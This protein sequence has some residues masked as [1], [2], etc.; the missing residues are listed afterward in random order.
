MEINKFT[1]KMIN[2]R[3]PSEIKSL[4]IEEQIDSHDRSFAQ[5]KSNFKYNGTRIYIK[6][7][8]D[9][10]N[11]TI[12]YITQS[13]INASLK[14]DMIRKV[15]NRT[16]KTKYIESMV[17]VKNKDRFN[18]KDEDEYIDYIFEV[19]QEIDMKWV[20]L[21][22]EGKSKDIFE[23]VCRYMLQEEEFDNFLRRKYAQKWI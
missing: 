8:T 16:I 22:E 2:D 10:N 14:H 17:M 23:D 6:E 5:Y 15:S 19:G 21:E 1:I 4:N 9:R 7:L 3:L 11:I 20:V 12:D 13:I 18:F